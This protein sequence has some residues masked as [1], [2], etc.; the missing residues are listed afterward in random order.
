MW[1][2]ETWA[3]ML[4]GAAARGCRVFVIA[5]GIANAPS[6]QAPLMAEEH[7]ILSRLLVLERTLGSEMK[8]SKGELR[9]GVFAAHASADD[10]A[11]RLREVREGLARAPWIREVIP[12]D[13]KTLAVLDRAQVQAA[14]GQDATA[15]AHDARPR[16]PQLHQKSQL[17]ARPGAIA[18]LVRQPGWDA[19]L[20]RSISTQSQETSRFADQLGYTE[21]DVDTTA[22][23][24]TDVMIRG[25]EQTLSETE[26]KRVSFYFS[27]GSQNQDPRGIAS[28]GEVSLIVSGVQ[29]A[30]GLVDLFYLMAR[31]NWI[32]SE[33]ELETFVPK[34]SALSSW[35]ARRFKAQ[36]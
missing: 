1:L 19:V 25:F 22:T 32:D 12:F 15:L 16:A 8:A 4:V 36:F 34:P 10:A 13:A 24:S 35:I 27:L 23:R 2:S 18:A 14:T 17:I 5:P 11:G 20:A 9:V 28:D 21:P 29:A 31:S 26:R 33:R 30:A 7:A 6:P 3:G